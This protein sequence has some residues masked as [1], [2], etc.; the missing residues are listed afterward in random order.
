M[1]RCCPS[2]AALLTGRYPHR[3][4]MAGN[5]TSLSLEVPTVAEELRDAGYATSMVGKWHLTA[6]VPI[7]DS[8]EHLKWPHHHA[9][10]APDFGQH[11]HTPAAGGLLYT[12]WVDA[13]K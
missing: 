11:S 12:M 4:N 3:V 1:S 5:G 13:R 2:R 8:A 9:Y 7:K 10:F 6:T